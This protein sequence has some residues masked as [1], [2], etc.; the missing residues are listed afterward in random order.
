MDIFVPIVI[1]LTK[2]GSAV[3][4]VST[5]VMER[6]RLGETLAKGHLCHRDRDRR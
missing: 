4:A 3:T 1:G 2:L 6:R 5:L